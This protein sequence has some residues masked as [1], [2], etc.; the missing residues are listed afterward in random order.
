M[1]KVE[2]IIFCLQ[3]VNMDE[4]GVTAQN[5][6][7]ALNPEYI[8]GLF[9]FSDIVSVLDVDSE[10][11]HQIEVDFADPEGNSVVHIEG[12]MPP[13]PTD[14]SNLPKE[15]KGIDISMNWN[16][17]NFKISGSYELTLKLDGQCI[18]NKS[19]FVKGKNE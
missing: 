10:I 3:A 5:I 1:A 12:S 17:V 6:L 13:L 8:P 15:Y 11:G 18:G 7:N 19:I 16:N 9:T 4:Q 2:N 14:N